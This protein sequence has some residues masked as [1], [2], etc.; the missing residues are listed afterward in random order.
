M[1]IGIREPLRM[2][3]H[4]NAATQPSSWG[5]TLLRCATR[6]RCLTKAKTASLPA[7]VQQKRVSCGRVSADDRMIPLHVGSAGYLGY[8]SSNLR[9]PSTSS[10]VPGRFIF[11][12][13]VAYSTIP[14][15]NTSTWQMVVVEEGGMLS[16]RMFS[17]CRA[18]VPVGG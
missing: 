13:I 6:L 5:A 10:F 2:S 17:A 18:T 7:N 16:L 14:D 11:C 8:S 1:T 15:H 3:R 9:P 4:G 12:F